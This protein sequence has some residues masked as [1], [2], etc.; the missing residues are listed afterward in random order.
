MTSSRDHREQAFRDCY[1]QHFDA[2][3]AYARRRTDQSA[4]AGDAV[5]ETFLVAWRRVGDIPPGDEARL[6]LYGVAR[7]VLANQR[8]GGERRHRLGERLRD[9]LAAPVVADHADDVVRRSA[10]LDAMQRLNPA[11]REILALSAWEQLEPREIA[12]VLGLSPGAVRTRLNRARTRLR[13]LIG[14]E[15]GLAGHQSGQRQTLTRGTR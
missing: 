15:P 11:D 2:V 4:D 3:L 14:D 13:D 8:R 6:W 5:A 7:R 9:R 1:A 12:T 10:L